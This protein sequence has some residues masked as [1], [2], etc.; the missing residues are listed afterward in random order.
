MVRR[1]GLILICDKP[2]AH[3]VLLGKV[4]ELFWFGA[5]KETAVNARMQFIICDLQLILHVLGDR[6]LG[7]LGCLCKSSFS[8]TQK[9]YVTLPAG[10]E[11]G[12]VF[13]C[14]VLRGSI[15]CLSFLGNGTSPPPP[16]R[17]LPVSYNGRRW[18]LE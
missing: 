10:F 3:C 16:P 2:L 7:D 5:A 18:P 15:I 9:Q 1:R 12:L 4:P 17:L 14:E 11:V 8:L 13:S 6:D